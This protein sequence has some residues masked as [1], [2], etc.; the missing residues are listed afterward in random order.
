MELDKKH[1]EI[2]MIER[3]ANLHGK[4]VL[5]VGCGDGRAT[6][7]LVGKARTIIAIDPDQGA[8]DNARV[9]VKGADFRVGSG[10]HLEFENESFDLVLF[11]FSLHHQESRQAL[12]EA[13]RVLRPGGQA[14]ILEPNV[15][16]EVEQFFC[17]FENEVQAIENAREAIETSHFTIEH[18]ET[19]F[20]DWVFEHKEELYEY[21]FEQHQLEPQES[22]IEEMNELLGEKI[23]MSPILLQDKV[24][25]F[26]LQK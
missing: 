1:I 3:V 23:S 15:D 17:L 7:A 8:I 13:Y 11:T 19:F 6:A 4:R 24:S 5:E 9:N 12:Q 21:F 18:Q 10:G 25:I 26:A 16:S 20:V 22:K 2:R 14:V